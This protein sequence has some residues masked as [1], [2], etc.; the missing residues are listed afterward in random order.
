MICRWHLI[1]LQIDM[2]CMRLKQPSCPSCMQVAAH[3]DMDM[4]K[5][6]NVNMNVDVW[7]RS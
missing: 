1:D 6:L 5:D 2:K 4:N 7:S 3:M